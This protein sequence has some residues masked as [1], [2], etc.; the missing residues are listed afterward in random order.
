MRFISALVLTTQNQNI[1]STQITLWKKNFLWLS[2]CLGSNILFCSWA[3]NSRPWLVQY[4]WWLSPQL[5]F[6]GSS[7]CF[8]AICKAA[9]RIFQ[10]SGKKPQTPPLVHGCNT[11]KANAKEYFIQL[12][13]KLTHCNGAVRNDSALLWQPPGGD[14]WAQPDAPSFVQA[15]L[16][17]L[18]TSPSPT[19][20]QSS[21]LPRL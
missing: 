10:P 14:A 4:L 20:H 19:P 17:D 8:Q 6:W 2:V 12:S 15:Q 3:P 13:A 9:K 11:R 21:D 1:S 16:G 18:N 5:L 7:V